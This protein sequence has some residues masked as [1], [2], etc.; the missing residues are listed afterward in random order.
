VFTNSSRIIGNSEVIL[1][2]DNSG[3][4]NRKRRSFDL[5]NTCTTNRFKAEAVRVI[6]LAMM[7]I[8]TK[9]ITIITP[10]TTLATCASGEWR[11][12]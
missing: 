9:R 6:L 3:I 4:G 7:S 12:R 1:S 8:A 5:Q 11:N 2:P 10:T